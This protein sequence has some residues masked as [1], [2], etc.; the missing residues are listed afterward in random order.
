[1]KKMTEIRLG[2]NAFDEEQEI[3]RPVNIDREKKEVS[4]QGS[5][6][7]GRKFP[8]SQASTLSG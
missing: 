6:D 4:K 8:A 5:E 7:G 3:F 2:A 1:M